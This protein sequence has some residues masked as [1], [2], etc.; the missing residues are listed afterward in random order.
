MKENNK[1]STLR[2]IKNLG[3]L[4]AIF[5]GLSLYSFNCAPPSFEVADNGSLTLSSTGNTITGNGPSLDPKVV[6]PQAL[7]TS[8]QIYESMMNLTGQK[9]TPTNTQ[10]QEFD[11]RAG[12]FGV[13]P[14]L[15]KVNA[16]MMIALTSF[17][18]EV[19][20]GLVAKEQALAAA[21]RTYFGSVNFGA[22]V[23]AL[24]NTSYQDAV[25]KM[26]NSFIG[27]APS[28]EET[29][30]FTTFKTD[31]IAAIPAANLTQPAQTRALILSSCAAV[32]SSFD[33]YTY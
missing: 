9:A 31:F 19:C 6:A 2:T 5:G 25:S 32:L 3:I 24:D 28:S 23:S 17:S 26:I 21:Q 16:P 12:S 20:N 30:L 15:E 11:R 1:Q 7:L 29:A 18:G 27:R 14:A 13:S 33:I 10:L 8:E 22:A 4:T